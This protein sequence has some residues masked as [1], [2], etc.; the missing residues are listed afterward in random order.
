MYL[1]NGTQTCF[2]ITSIGVYYD[3]L[4]GEEL[5]AI[6]QTGAGDPALTCPEPPSSSTQWYRFWVLVKSG[7]IS[8]GGYP[9][10]SS[11][12]YTLNI[13]RD[14][15]ITTNWKF[16]WNGSQWI[17]L[18]GSEASGT[19]VAGTEKGHENDVPYGHFDGSVYQTAGE[20]WIFWDGVQGWCDTDPLYNVDPTGG[21][22]SGVGDNFWVRKAGSPG[23]TRCTV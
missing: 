13:H 8:C 16:Q 12:D 17:T 22:G 18:A 7:V 2:R 11:G 19:P 6:I 4:N 21:D 15:V 5:G 14:P 20:A 9:A 3:G 10:Q 23:L 1:G